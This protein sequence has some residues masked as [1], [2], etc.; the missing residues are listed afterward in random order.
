[1]LSRNGTITPG[2]RTRE[3]SFQGGENLIQD[4]HEQAQ[5]V[6]N[7]LSLDRQLLEN[8]R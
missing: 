3:N 8:E 1:M 4:G 2:Q 7:I 6:A 5:L